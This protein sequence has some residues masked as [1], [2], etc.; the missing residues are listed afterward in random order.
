MYCNSIARSDCSLAYSTVEYSTV[1][2][3]LE[4]SCKWIPSKPAQFIPEGHP[5][6]KLSSLFC[7]PLLYRTTFFLYLASINVSKQRQIP[8]FFEEDHGIHNNIII[9]CHKV[10]GKYHTG[11]TI[12]IV[13]DY[14]RLVY[15]GGV[16]SV[17]GSCYLSFWAG[18]EGLLTLLRAITH[19]RLH[20]TVPWYSTC[21]CSFR[22]GHVT[23]FSE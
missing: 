23:Q 9:S 14:S 15:C 7:W 22:T 4:C 12:G 18:M 21:L 11:A 13:V 3:V 5:S 19:S 20:D 16:A 1:L 2:V 17:F 10:V 8:P 6:L